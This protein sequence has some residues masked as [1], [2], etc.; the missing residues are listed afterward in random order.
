M[1]SDRDLLARLVAFDTTSSLSNLPMADFL[2]GYLDR[3]GVRINRIA[4]DSGD[5][6]NVLV[7]AGPERSDGSGL[8]LSGHMDVVPATE[9]EW[10]SD[11][12]TLTAVGDTFVARGA[13]DMKGFLALAVNRF[14]AL[15]PAALEH[16]L[17]L[18]FTY[19]EETGTLG[20]RRFS[21]SWNDRALLPR[22]VLIGEPTSL[23]VVR[24]HKGMLRLRLIFEGAAAHSGYPHLG[25]N[26]IEPAGRVIVALA[27]L[28]QR[29]AG[30]RPPNGEQF[31]EVPFAAL[32]VG[33]VNG[34][35][36]A[37]VI[38]DRC[39]VQL[40]IR[41]LPGMVAEGMID[42]IRDIITPA[43]AGAPFTL[44]YVSESPAMI[45]NEEADI[46]RQLC[47]EVGQRGSRSV[48]F[49]TDAGWLQRMGLECVLFGPGSIEVAHRA[50]EFVPVAEL[51]RAG[52]V[53]D[54]IIQ[55]RCRPA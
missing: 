21:E 54:R 34:G 4:S 52:G 35:S 14:A 33:T 13:A 16:P 2:A 43:A 9:P 17:L 27:D 30:E 38:P 19:D 45:L 46:Y 11:P 1:L 29:M 8:I 55:Q 12:F 6:V 39:E 15:D 49:A 41:L 51:D 24:S 10:R 36:A 47:A 32:N 22:S 20:A 23:Q 31:P 40:G 42:R 50:N 26:A 25:R 7:A 3:P 37:N 53:L 28:R 5:K 48:M 44:E 18:L